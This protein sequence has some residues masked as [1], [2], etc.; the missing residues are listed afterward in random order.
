MIPLF[1]TKRLPSLLYDKP[2]TMKWS[3]NRPSFL[4]YNT[5]M[6]VWVERLCVL[7]GSNIILGS[8]ATQHR[9]KFDSVSA[10]FLQ[11]KCSNI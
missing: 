4:V 9:T 10:G 6:F 3:C 1:L 7:V 5:I 11:H 2:Y 8:K